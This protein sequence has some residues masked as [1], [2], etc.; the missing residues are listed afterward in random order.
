MKKMRKNPKDKR[1]KQLIKIYRLNEL[2]KGTLNFSSSR[3]FYSSVYESPESQ[4][5]E[6]FCGM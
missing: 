6:I 1:L 3:I 2:S 4:D 5:L